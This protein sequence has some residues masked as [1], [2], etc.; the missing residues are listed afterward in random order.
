MRGP[1]SFTTSDKISSGPQGERSAE[2]VLP[3]CST[4]AVVLSRGRRARLRR[5][6]QRPGLHS[7]RNHSGGCNRG[8]HQE[9]QHHETRQT[10]PQALHCVLLALRWQSSRSAAL[11]SDATSGQHSASQIFAPGPIHGAPS[12]NSVARADA[13][14][15]T[16]AWFSVPGILTAT[17][18]HKHNSHTAA[19]SGGYQRGLARGLQRGRNAFGY[20]KLGNCPKYAQCPVHICF[21]FV[22]AHFVFLFNWSHLCMLS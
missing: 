3:C 8:R 14:W 4:I 20:M 13:R 19:P 11:R 22:L 2:E 1:Q 16:G 9:R 10:P 15:H 21:M 12:T 5:G 17:L 7:Q 18:C 6:S